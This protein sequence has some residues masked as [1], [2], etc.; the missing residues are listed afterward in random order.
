MPNY[1][2][3]KA[4]TEEPKK[5]GDKMQKMLDSGRLNFIVKDVENDDLLESP[6]GRL[7]AFDALYAVCCCSSPHGI[8]FPVS[9]CVPRNDL[10]S[11]LIISV[12]LRTY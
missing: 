2:F 6:N 3:T 7:P 1:L 8:S 10:K 4:K 11:L 5:H 9:V 12:L